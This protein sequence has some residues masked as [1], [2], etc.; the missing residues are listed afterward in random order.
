[1]SMTH[2]VQ[3]EN[4]PPRL[5]SKLR[6]AI[7][8]RVRRG[9]SISAACEEAG[10]STAGWHKAMKRPAVQDHLRGVQERFVAEVEASKSLYK[11]QALDAAR[12]LMLNAKSQTVRARMVEFL[13]GDGKSL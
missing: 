7:E 4:K 13:A 3:I 6:Q 1:M 9:V 11:A 8:G 12:D 2:I 5:S 10:L